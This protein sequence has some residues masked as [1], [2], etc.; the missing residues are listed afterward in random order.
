[1]KRQAALRRH[2]LWARLLLWGSVT[3]IVACALLVVSARSD[4]M[5]RT[6]GV[7][8]RAQSLLDR[9]R[10]EEAASVL[11]CLTQEQPNCARAHSALADIRSAQ[12]REAQ[13]MEQ[14]RSLVELQP[15]NAQAYYDL[16]ACA[17][18]LRQYDVAEEYLA[19]RVREVPKDAYARRLIAFVYERRNRP[20]R[21]LSQLQSL[22][23]LS[24]PNAPAT[25]H[26]V[27]RIRGRLT[28]QHEEA[29][30]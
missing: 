20:D 8:H 2:P 1:M 11:S 16:V 28:R 19:R 22:S 12:G 26:S 5:R 18:V 25:A 21:A 14:Y 7:L 23:D 4:R 6:D 24:R 13:A 3:A 9:G 10:I 30:G 27:A 17:L 15:D 29:G